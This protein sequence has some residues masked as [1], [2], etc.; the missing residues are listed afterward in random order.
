MVAA[1]RV[2]QR[3]RAASPF[4]GQVGCC[5]MGAAPQQDA[6]LPQGSGLGRAGERKVID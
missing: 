4:E 1:I 5:N 2:T 6:H 3:V